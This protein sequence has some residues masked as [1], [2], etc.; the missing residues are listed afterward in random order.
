MAS[1]ISVITRSAASGLSVCNVTA[2]VVEVRVGFRVKRISAHVRAVALRF[3]FR[4]Q[5]G[6]GLLAVNGLHPAAF[7]VVITA[8]EH[9]ARLRKL[10]RSTRLRHPAR[11]RQRSASALRG[12]VFEFLFRL[13]GEVY[14]HA[15]KIREKRP[16]GNAVERV[17]GWSQVLPIL[18]R[19]DGV[20]IFKPM[21][22]RKT[23]QI[24]GISSCNSRW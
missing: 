3:G 22:A 2:Y 17:V 14:F 8:V 6:K 24:L 19:P 1:K 5:T 13:G 4:F 15:F 12:E 16:W 9:F 10:R 21:T 18:K 7:Q 20:V 23:V 11:A